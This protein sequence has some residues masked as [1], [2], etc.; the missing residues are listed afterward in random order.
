MNL[1]PILILIPVAASIIEYLL[2]RLK[3]NYDGIVPLVSSI[4]SLGLSIYAILK[5]QPLFSIPW[6]S[7]WGINYSLGLNGIS[8][9]FIVLLSFVFLMIT[10]L[11]LN[12]PKHRTYWYMN[13][14]IQALVFNFILTQDLVV[15]VISWEFIWIPAF[16]ILI[17]TDRKHYSIKFSNI[18]FVAQALL[19]SG[20]IIMIGRFSQIY[21]FAFWLFLIATLLRSY[22][23]ASERFD[24]EV[25]LITTVIL[26]LLPII[27]LINTILPT[28]QYQIHANIQ[29]IS[30]FICACI[31]IWILRLI[32]SRSIST[33]SFS[34]MFIFSS[35]IIIWLL[36]PTVKIMQLCVQIIIAKTVLNVLLIYYGN[37]T[38]F[39]L[40]KWVFMLSLV[41]SFGF[42]GVVIGLPAAKLF[43]LWNITQHQITVAMF[44][45]FFVLFITTIIK[46]G[47]LFNS[48]RTKAVPGQKWFE[49]VKLVTVC[50][51]FLGVVVA[52]LDPSYLN[53]M[54]RNYHQTNISRGLQ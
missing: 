34:N 51:I 17:N 49:I 23:R 47:A 41:L 28:F 52:S 38:P 20:T 30:I 16:I 15:R 6:I 36:I 3:I 13:L 24:T 43:S 18:W 39:S 2:T 45:L 19:I 44:S 25:S 8:N 11:S 33:I 26:P 14:L 32:A 50:I 12:K 48:E 54:V 53:Q 4:S 31:F 40:N 1:L 5:L 9:I 21:N 10:V 7:R 29:P 42:A 27:F 22:I 35:L 37:K 46:M